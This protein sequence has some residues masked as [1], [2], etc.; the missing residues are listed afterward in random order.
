MTVLH[1]PHRKSTGPPC[2]L[3]SKIINNNFVFIIIIIIILPISKTLNSTK[4]SNIH[5][6]I[7]SIGRFNTSF[8]LPM[9]IRKKDIHE[10]RNTLASLTRLVQ[11]D[12]RKF[13]A[14][15][16]LWIILEHLR[17]AF[18]VGCFQPLAPSQLFLNSSHSVKTQ[19]K[20]NFSN[21]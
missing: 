18:N 14:C 21:I 11:C 19:K 3:Q 8:Q 1:I 2:S 9:T 10:R 6:D 13:Q 17:T 5:S 20:L 16:Q 7:K 15:Q 4:Q 12:R